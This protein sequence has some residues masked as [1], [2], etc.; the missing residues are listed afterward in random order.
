M[1]S[2]IVFVHGVRGDPQTTWTWSDVVWP[3]DLIPSALPTARILSWGYD[4]QI[5]EFWQST[6]TDHS[7]TIHAKCLISD[8]A[9]VRNEMVMSQ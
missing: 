5:V 4:A 3:K 7:I 1:L 8:L 9:G 2:S 6:A